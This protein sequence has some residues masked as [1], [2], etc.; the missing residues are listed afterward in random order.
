MRTRMVGENCVC[1]PEKKTP[2][3]TAIGLQRTDHV[4][5]HT[6]PVEMVNLEALQQ[7]S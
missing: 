2:N 4:Q 3:Q 7:V 5:K 6:L 1:K